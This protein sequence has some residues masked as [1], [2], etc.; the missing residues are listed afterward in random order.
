M[1]AEPRTLGYTALWK[2]VCAPWS[3]SCV[4]W[5]AAPGC[6]CTG[7][8]ANL[9]GG[10]PLTCRPSWLCVPLSS[11]SLAP[12]CDLRWTEAPSRYPAGF[13]SGPAVLAKEVFGLTANGG[14]L[15][16]MQDRLRGHAFGTTLPRP[17]PQ[18]HFS[19][20]QLPAGGGTRGKFQK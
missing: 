2:H 6:W 9:T 17:K 5:A 11:T 19:S 20:C 3:A 8:H 16:P 1:H 10:N 15:L 18:V 12:I 4:T 14:G 7:C 13:L